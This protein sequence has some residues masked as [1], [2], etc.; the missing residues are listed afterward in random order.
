MIDALGGAA[1]AEIYLAHRPDVTADAIHRALVAQPSPAHELQIEGSFPLNRSNVYE[2]VAPVGLD[3]D[4]PVGESAHIPQA[5]P[6]E[7]AGRGVGEES[8]AVTQSGST[9]IRREVVLNINGKNEKVIVYTIQPLTREVYV[10]ADFFMDTEE[11]AEHRMPKTDEEIREIIESRGPLKMKTVE[12]EE[13]VLEGDRK[14]TIRRVIPEDW[15]PLHQLNPE[16]PHYDPCPPLNYK[17]GQAL[18]DFDGPT[19]WIADEDAPFPGYDSASVASIYHMSGLFVDLFDPAPFTCELPVEVRDFNNDMY[20]RGTYLDR[21]VEITTLPG[22]QKVTLYYSQDGKTLIGMGVQDAVPFREGYYWDYWYRIFRNDPP[23]E[24]PE[25][26]F[27]W[28]SETQA[29]FAVYYPDGSIRDYGYS[30]DTLQQTPIFHVR[31]PI[32]AK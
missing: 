20:R 4:A 6:E 21:P 1:A 22:V 9:V 30:L 15:V 29:M 18:I 27:N 28:G 24:R 3:P 23:S 16:T 26:G 25:P 5:P 13:V 11:N 14:I 31:V 2:L 17:D 19:T 32:I 10:P 8:A 7:V 12:T